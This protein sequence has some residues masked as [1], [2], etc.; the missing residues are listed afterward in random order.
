MTRLRVGQIYDLIRRGPYSQSTTCL[1]GGDFI[2]KLQYYCP[3]QGLLRATTNF[4]TFEVVNLSTD[5]LHS[6]L[7]QIL[8]KFL[9]KQAAS[10]NQLRTTWSLI[11]EISGKRRYNSPSK[12]RRTDRTKVNSTNEL[13]N[14][15][16]IYFEN[17]LNLKS[18]TSQDY[19]AI[20]PAS[21]NLPIHQGPI[22]TEEVEQAINQ[23]KNGKY[24]GFDH[25]ITP[26]V[27]KYGGKWITNQLRDICNDIYENQQKPTQFNINII[28]PIPKQGNKTL[29]TNYK[30]ISL[31]SVAAKTY[32]RVLL[33][34]IWEPLD[35]ILRVDQEGFRKGRGDI[36][37][38]RTYHT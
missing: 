30:C 28:I 18:D 25:S 27:L 20:P 31:V 35:S 11:N 4:A 9:L 37:Q 5:L 38:I 29:M 2:H 23:P 14:E 32:N 33:N 24:P 36:D 34:R 13:I 7:A 15:W 10:Y 6:T 16:R 21:E 12:I 17:L 19:E 1:H 3:Q 26:E 8:N 22:T